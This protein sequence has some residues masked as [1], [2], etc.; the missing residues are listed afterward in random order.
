MAAAR[1][2]RG[3]SCTRSRHELARALLLVLRD[4]AHG[5]KH[6][7][8]VLL[9]AKS[10]QVTF[11]C[12]RTIE[13]RKFATFPGVGGGVPAAAP[14]A[15][16]AKT[17]SDEYS[18]MSHEFGEPWGGRRWELPEFEVVQ[19]LGRAFGRRSVDETLAEVVLCER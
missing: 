2:T 9:P 8:D 15:K 10:I 13:S 4:G 5:Q 6:P 7:G 14:V 18:P 12:P 11:F 17:E 19:D 16:R 3:R 1:P